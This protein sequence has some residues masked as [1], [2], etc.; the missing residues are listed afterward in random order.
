MCA[1]LVDCCSDAVTHG[2]AFGK[3]GIAAVAG[4]NKM[5]RMVLCLDDALKSILRQ[6]L[7]KCSSVT[8]CRDSRAGRLCVRF[9]AVRVGAAG[10][11]RICKGLLG[12]F[13]I[14]DSSAHGTLKTTNAIMKRFATTCQSVSELSTLDVPFRKHLRRSVKIVCIDSASN[15]TLAAELMRE[16]A[17][18]RTLTP[19]MQLMVRDGA[20][21]ARR[22][23]S[24]PFKA[25]A[26]LHEISLRAVH[27]RR[28][29]GQMIH[30]SKAFIDF[31][32][33]L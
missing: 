9:G 23:A 25:V 8:L 2:R 13:P 12:W 22:L 14:G 7:Q 28:S 26:G 18:L 4:G 15:E 11:V 21:G 19:N 1:S 33:F 3:G 17:V 31:W 27:G 6:R 30:Q 24:R 10:A 16:P 20:H 5:R 29:P 32:N